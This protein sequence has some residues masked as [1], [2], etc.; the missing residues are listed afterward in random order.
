MKLRIGTRGSTLALAQSKIVGDALARVVGADVEVEYVEISTHGDRTT[1]SLVGLSETGVFVTA[2]RERLLDD[3]CDLVVHSLKDMPVA[4]FDRLVVG[5]ILARGDARDALCAGGLSLAELHIGARVGTSSPRRAAQMRALRPDLAV[6]DIRGNV[7]SRLAKIG[8][9]FDAVVLALSGLERLGR[10]DAADEIFE[11]DDMMPA[12][13]QGALAV[14]LREDAPPELRSAVAELN[15]A[16]TRACV[17]AERAVLQIL[18]AGC[19]APMG[20]LATRAGDELTLRARVVDAEGK[21][22]LN[23]LSRGPLGHA[24]RMGRATGFAL[25]GRGAVSLMTTAAT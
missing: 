13:G 17:T 20:A 24:E 9:E 19:A 2:L 8:G 18:Q 1:G 23:E 22:S 15:D 16:G 25:L 21:L 3:D 7:D 4:E 14:E 10:A 6:V 5:A 11:P 12:P